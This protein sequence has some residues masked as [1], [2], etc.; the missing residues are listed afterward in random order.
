M[1]KFPLKKVDGYEKLGGVG[2]D[3]L[4]QPRSGI[5][6]IEGY[7]RSERVVSL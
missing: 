1:Q 5:V 4:I 3:I 6:A 7:L 2:K